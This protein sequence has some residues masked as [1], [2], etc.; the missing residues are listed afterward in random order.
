MLQPDKTC[1]R[2]FHS[3]DVVLVHRRWCKEIDFLNSSFVVPVGQEEVAAAV[4]DFEP[5]ALNEQRS[6]AADCFSLR[7]GAGEYARFA[8]V[9]QCGMNFNPFGHVKSVWRFR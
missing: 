4:I 3:I 8:H 6:A 5:V 2:L 1:E 9:A 7:A